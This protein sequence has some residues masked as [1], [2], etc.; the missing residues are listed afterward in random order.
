MPWN[1]DLTGA[2]LNI[3]QVDTNLLRVMA[4]P[5]TGKTFAM[6]RRVMRLLEEGIDARRVLAVTFTRTAAASLVK[7]LRDLGVPGC[8]DIRAGTLHAFCFSLL[9]KRDVFTYLNRV[10][11]PLVTFSSHG[12]LQFEACPLLQDVQAGGTFGGKRDCTKRI[13]AFE[14]AW[15]RLQSDAPGWPLDPVDNQF[16]RVVIDWLRFH[17]AMLV[18]E[19]VPEAL[20][21][22]RNNPAVVELNW[23]EHV[24]VDEYQ[25]LNRAEQV[26][27]DLLAGGGAV[28]I[29]GDVDQSIYSFRFA[30]P[31]GIVDYSTTHPGTHDENL[32]D[33]RRCARLIVQIASHLI[34]H[35]HPPGNTPRLQALPT[36]SEGQVRIVQWNSLQEEAEGLAGF[37]EVLINERG[38]SPGEI[39]ILSPRRLIG[40]GIRDALVRRGVSTH[41]FYHE[42]ALEDD[43]AQLAFTLLSLLAN[44]EDRV[45]LR[46]WLGYGSPSWREGGYR[47]LRQHCERSGNSPRGALDDID[48]GTLT[49]NRIGELIERYRELKRQVADYTRLDGQALVDK[50]LPDGQSWCKALREA[51]QLKLT[52]HMDAA[53]LLDALRTSVSQPEMPEEGNF[54]RVMSLQKSKGLTSRV[55]IVAGCIQGLIPNEARDEPPDVQRALLQEQRRLFYVALTRAQEISVLSSVTRLDRDLAFKMGAKVRGY[56]GNTIASMFMAELGPAAPAARNGSA[57]VHNHFI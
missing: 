7:E 48:A 56:S 2:A 3:A 23:F 1:T 15:A 29:V 12:V 20:R 41:S 26:L 37:V 16:H 49:L 4:G 46:F 52:E 38:Y 42:E 47:T 22:L 45:A 14:A 33:C 17:Q 32:I 6:K 5:G 31:Q 34:S 55:T 50:L 53:K 25:D 8:Q 18:G 51:A 39:L 19:L 57:W 35:N 28:A 30:H 36:N 43:N 27:L 40:Y 21:Y 11:R 13:R 44:P 10:A 9:A 24:V 54:V